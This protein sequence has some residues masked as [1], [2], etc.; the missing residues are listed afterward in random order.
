ML[1]HQEQE[2]IVKKNLERMRPTNWSSFLLPTEIDQ[3]FHA[4]DNLW[5]LYLMKK[6]QTQFNK[7]WTEWEQSRKLWA[8]TL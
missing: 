7:K 5:Y 4:I 8:D 2:L 1:I 3:I 6:K